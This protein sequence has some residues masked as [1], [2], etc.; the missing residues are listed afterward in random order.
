MGGKGISKSIKFFNETLAPKARNFKSSEQNDI[1]KFL[2]TS[3]EEGGKA[4]IY[5]VNT[6]SYSLPRI[7][8]HT[9]SQPLHQVISELS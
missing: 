1:D 7:T 2:E 3:L 4:N 8:A 6:L 9:T 5:A